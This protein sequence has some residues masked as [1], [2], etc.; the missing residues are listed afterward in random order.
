MG[1]VILKAG[2]LKCSTAQSVAKMHNLREKYC[3]NADPSK[4]DKNVVLLDRDIRPW[5][6]CKERIR[7]TGRYERNPPKRTAVKMYDLVIS[8][9]QESEKENPY[10]DVDDFIKTSF[11]WMKKNFGEENIYSAVVHFDEGTPHV[12]A[13]LVPI[14]KDG[15]LCY[16]DLLG[17]P[18]LLRDAQTSIA[19]EMAHLGLQRGLEKSVAKPVE[20]KTYDALQK[21]ALRDVVPTRDEQE[22]E[23]EYMQRVNR[24]F[25]VLRAQSTERTMKMQRKLDEVRTENKRLK[26]SQ[27]AF[28]GVDLLMEENKKLKKDLRE[29][30]AALKDWDHLVSVIEGHKL[31]NEEE[32]ILLS[33]L[34]K[35]H[36]IDLGKANNTRSTPDSKR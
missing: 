5:E 24:T 3:D 11:N 10:M 35:A 20:Q 31:S 19:K 8:Y 26:E 13:M 29:A 14:T 32:Q 4:I 34:Q 36:E 28:E 22:S 25:Q 1:Y 33:I 16:R 9:S 18:Y 17:Q 2:K 7:S 12:H 27:R 21:E 15:R 6:F 30:D 23:A